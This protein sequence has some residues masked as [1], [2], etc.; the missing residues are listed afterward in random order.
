MFIP[1][2]LRIDHL[3][4]STPDHTGG[5]TFLRR[6]RLV[7]PGQSSPT[8]PAP[9]RMGTGA[10]RGVGAAWLAGG[11]RRGRHN[12]PAEGGWWPAEEDGGWRASL[13]EE[14]RGMGAVWRA[15]GEWGAAGVEGEGALSESKWHDLALLSP[16]HP[17]PPWL[18]DR[19]RHETK[20]AD[21]APFHVPRAPQTKPPS[22]L[23][24]PLPCPHDQALICTD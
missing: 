5:G 10:A 23:C 7:G 4:L 15:D 20:S 2:H 14:G 3:L 24:S 21:R 8:P 17:N 12:S 9:R 22:G 1:W 18:S 13:V 19:A 6:P 16:P 11:G